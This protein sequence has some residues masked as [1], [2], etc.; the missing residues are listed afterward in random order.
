MGFLIQINQNSSGSTKSDIP[1]TKAFL[2]RFTEVIFVLLPLEEVIGKLLLTQHF[3][4]N[5]SSLGRIKG[6]TPF[7]ANVRPQKR[8]L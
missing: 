8:F 4:P 5:H 3:T 2:G 6:P 1:I 7:I